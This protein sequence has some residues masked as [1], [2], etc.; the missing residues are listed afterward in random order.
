MCRLPVLRC[1][2]Q[3]VA[4]HNSRE[5]AWIIIKDKVYDITGESARRDGAQ[6]RTLILQRSTFNVPG[7]VSGPACDV[8]VVFKAQGLHVAVLQRV[9]SLASDRR[10]A[11]SPRFSPPWFLPSP[12]PPLPLYLCFRLLFSSA[13]FSVDWMDKHPGGSE[14]VQLMAGRDATDAFASYHPFTDKPRKV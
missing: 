1:A 13:P 3:E 12:R 9:V 5:S 4:K 11:Y 6:L 7:L 8:P 10:S 2:A 14:V